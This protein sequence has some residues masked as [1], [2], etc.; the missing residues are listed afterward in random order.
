M[1]TSLWSASIEIFN[2]PGTCNEWLYFNSQNANCIYSMLLGRSSHIVCPTQQ[3]L[4]YAICILLKYNNSWRVDE[5]TW[6]HLENVFN[7]YKMSQ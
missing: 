2:L 5:Q 1:H 7:G 3:Q 6:K 4:M